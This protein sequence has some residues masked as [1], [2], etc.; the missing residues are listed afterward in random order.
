MKECTEKNSTPDPRKA[1]GDK[2]RATQSHAAG[3]MTSGKKAVVHSQA[4]R[5]IGHTFHSI[6]ESK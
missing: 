4:N 1:G 2:G 5:D 6:K 3:N